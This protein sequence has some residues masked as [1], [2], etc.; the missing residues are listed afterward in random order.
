MI[1]HGYWRSSASYRVRI[2][3]NLKRLAYGQLSYDLRKGEQSQAALSMHAPMGLVPALEVDGE[4]LSQ[5]LAILE[6]LE[7]SHPLPPLLPADRT[8]RAIVRA[9]A[10]TIACDIHPLNNLRVLQALRRDFSASE[11]E[12]QHWISRWINDGFSALEIMVRR[13]GQ[14]FCFGDMPTMADCCLVPQIYNARRFN[15][16]LSPFTALVAVDSR[17]AELDAFT[18]AAP[19]RQPDA[20]GVSK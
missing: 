12:V 8:Q 13:H 4:S 14:G 9:M 2:G 5:S 3:A 1:L 18:R 17:C 19:E 16:D 11:E 20:D 6:W 7:E 15:V 10:S